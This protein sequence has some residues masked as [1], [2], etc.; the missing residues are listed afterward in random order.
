MT[1]QLYPET[2]K[3]HCPDCGLTVDLP[4]PMGKRGLELELIGHGDD[5]PFY[6]G[7]CKHGPVWLYQPYEDKERGNDD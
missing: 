5:G 2:E 1:I 7:V 6:E 3:P 4:V